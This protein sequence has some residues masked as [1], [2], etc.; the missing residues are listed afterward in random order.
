[1]KYQIRSVQHLTE[2]Q[3][4]SKLHVAAQR[5]SQYA[6]TVLLFIFSNGRSAKKYGAYEVSFHKYNF[7]H[8][9]GIK[10]ETLHAEEFYEACLAGN[11]KR[12]D[13][14]PTHSV[15]NMY[16]KVSVITELLDFK[17]SKCYRIGEKDLITKDNDFEMATG[18]NAGVVGYDHRIPQKGTNNVDKTKLAMPTTLI[19][20]PITQLV[21]NPE[22]IMFILQRGLK[23]DTYRKVYYE[24]KRDLLKKEYPSFAGEIQKLITL[25]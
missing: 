2:T 1:M 10:S 23:E 4:L 7:M 15:T 22:K 17:Y 11:I 12:E 13:C 16:E 18:N 5:Y 25:S 20:T 9:A 6:D 19:T 24:I 3:L 14:S 21:S 8:L